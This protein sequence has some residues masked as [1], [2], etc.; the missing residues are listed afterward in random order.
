MEIGDLIQEVITH[1]HGNKDG[2]RVGIVRDVTPI[3][4]AF[5]AIWVSWV[6]GGDDRLDWECLYSPDFITLSKNEKSS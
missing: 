1:E 4:K 6:G 2:G 3:D 5:C